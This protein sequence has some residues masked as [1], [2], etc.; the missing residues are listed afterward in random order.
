MKYS[1][2]LRQAISSTGLPLRRIANKFDDYG[3]NI[4]PS[5]LSRL[6]TG[7][8]SPATDDINKIIAMVLGIDEYK[9]R[10][11]A[12]LGK[13]P[14]DLQKHIAL[15]NSAVGELLERSAANESSN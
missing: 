4:D 11:A 9:L 3:V 8:S 7:K 2:M 14:D 13:I 10:L 15:K 12:Y 6:Q 5:Y 1:E